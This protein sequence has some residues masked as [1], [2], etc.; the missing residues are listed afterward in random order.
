MRN[1]TGIAIMT[2]ALAAPLFAAD[3]IRKFSFDAEG[4]STIRL[5]HPVGELEITGADVKA[6]EVRMEIDCDSRNCRDKSDDIRL[7]SHV[8]GGELHLEVDGYPTF[9]K[10]LSVNLEIRVPRAMAVSIDH[11]VGEISIDGVGG[12][13]DLES[14]VGEV[15]IRGD[16]KSFRSARV[17][18][19]V[20]ESN[21]KVAGDRVEGDSFLFIG[22]EKK[23]RD[24]RG[25]S[26]LKVEVG[27]GEVTVRLD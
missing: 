4:V 18:V 2:L 1:Y 25:E 11:G 20:G 27:V 21:L 22:G 12:D 9:G 5:D 17:E 13:I 19:G 15:E 3:D 14:G 24:G 23:W 8:K 10:G 7:E 6:I 16:A 26:S